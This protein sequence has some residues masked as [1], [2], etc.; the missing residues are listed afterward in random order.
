ML[1][2]H[3]D[4]SYF[5]LI[6]AI[7]KVLGL[8]DAGFIYGCSKSLRKIFYIVNFG[9]SWRFRESSTLTSNFQILIKFLS[10][11]SGE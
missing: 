10:L 4:F 7:K 6:Y 9:N 8:S 2:N 11:T 5:G 3:P 1:L